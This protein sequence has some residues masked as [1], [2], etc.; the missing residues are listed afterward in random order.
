MLTLS[1]DS[2]PITLQGFY[3][4]AY[5]ITWAVPGG[6]ASFLGG[7]KQGRIQ[8]WTLGGSNALHVR[9]FLALLFAIGSTAVWG[10]DSPGFL[11]PPLVS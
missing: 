3:P 9:S 4:G 7:M 6:I 11:D 8:S 5:S 1:K 2:Q 10:H